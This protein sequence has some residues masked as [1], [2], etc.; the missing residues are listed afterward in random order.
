MFEIFESLP[1]KLVK[2]THIGNFTHV[3][4]MP[5]A[6]VLRE[7]EAALY[8]DT[9]ERRLLILDALAKSHQQHAPVE[10]Y[11]FTANQAAFGLLHQSLHDISAGFADFAFGE[12]IPGNG[13]KTADGKFVDLRVNSGMILIWSRYLLM[14]QEKQKGIEAKARVLTWMMGKQ[15][16]LAEA[17]AYLAHF[18]ERVP[19]SFNTPEQIEQAEKIGISLVK[20]SDLDF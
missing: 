4:E 13:T 1:E 17:V 14:Q 3:R 7:V 18:R 16:T 11:C 8:D 2:K 12:D 15:E 5:V 6:T 9:Q 20:I 19:T 10:D